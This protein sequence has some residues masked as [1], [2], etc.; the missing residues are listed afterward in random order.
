MGVDF[1]SR[2]I[3]FNL[4]LSHL[5]AGDY[6]QECA[7]GYTA[8]FLKIAPE[9]MSICLALLAKLLCVF[10]L[11]AAA[12]FACFPKFLGHGGSPWRLDFNIHF[13]R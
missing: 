13:L 6:H 2:A 9:L 1:I 10:G 11:I 7:G 8:D 3:S 12:L 5:P 4:F